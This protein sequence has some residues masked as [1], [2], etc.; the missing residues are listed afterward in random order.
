[1]AKHNLLVIKTYGNKSDIS[2]KPADAKEMDMDWTYLRK[3]QKMA[4]NR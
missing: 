2:N 1:M 4:P 3:D